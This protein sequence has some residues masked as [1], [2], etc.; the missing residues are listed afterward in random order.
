MGLAPGRRVSGAGSGFRVG[1]RTAGG[2]GGGFHFFRG[3]LLALAEFSVW[4]GWL[5]GYY[6]ME[7]RHSPDISEFPSVL[8][9]TSFGNWCVNWYIPCL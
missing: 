8:S 6:S 4:W 3:S 5:L 9:L 2:G 7:F 1:W